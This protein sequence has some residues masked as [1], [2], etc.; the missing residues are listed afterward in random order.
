MLRYIIPQNVDLD[1][2]HSSQS[3]NINALSPPAVIKL[4]GSA[5]N[6]VRVCRDSTN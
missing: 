3:S 6:E 5:G 2:P 1:I 4:K